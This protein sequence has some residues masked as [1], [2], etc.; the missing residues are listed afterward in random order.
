[1][2]RDPD[3]VSQQEVTRFLCEHKVDLQLLQQ[4][5]VLVEW[6]ARA[7]CTKPPVDASGIPI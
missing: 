1:M 3:N 6:N 5:A 2:L 4:A 7:L